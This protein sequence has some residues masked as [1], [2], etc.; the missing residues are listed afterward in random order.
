MK[1]LRYIF[2][3]IVVVFFV[4]CY[5]VNEEIVINENG[6]GTYHTK[7]DMSALI[8]MMQTFAGEEELMK[9]GL[10][11]SIDTTIYMRNVLDSAKDAT[12]E[13]KELLKDGK[14]GLRMDIKEKIFKADLD[15]PFKNYD[16]LQMLMSGAGSGGL[17]NVFKNVFGK[18]DEQ[19]QQLDAPKD[20]GSG[21]DELNTVFDV[22]VKNGL[23]SKIL[24]Q[25]KYKAL[26]EKPELAQM[27]AMTGAG[28]EIM[29]TTTIKL[30]R[31][32]KKVDNTNIKLSD[33]KKTV[34]I[35]YNLLD[36]FDNPEKFSYTLEF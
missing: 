25:E 30:P 7:M 10:D 33:D 8:D 3:T 15:F 6:S 4:S 19:K 13:Q 16:G 9:Q 35:K 28:M 2:L 24:N 5:E 34:T 1:K 18:A 31:P 12:P 36:I 21:L 14:M 29:Y 32:V 23:I 26:K 11:K 20:P 22:T 27:K 17:A